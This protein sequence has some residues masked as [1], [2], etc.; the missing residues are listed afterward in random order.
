MVGTGILSNN[1]RS[2][3][4]ERYTAFWRMT[5]IL[6][7]KPILIR[8]YTNFNPVTDLDLISEFDFSSY[9]TMFPYNI[10][11]GCGVPIEDTHSS[12][13]LVLPND[14]TCMCSNVEIN[15]CWTLFSGLLSF[16]HPSDLLFFASYKTM[17]P[18]DH[19]LCTWVQY[20]TFVDWSAKAALLVFR[21]A[22]TT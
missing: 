9:Y 20:A 2:P 12:G 14:G 16:E 21:S 13:K 4:L 8:H 11:K 5:I 6:Q 18:Q 19:L 10:C 15:L 1:L 17:T 3:S 7:W 22:R